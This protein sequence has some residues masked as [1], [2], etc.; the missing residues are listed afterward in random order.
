MHVTHLDG[1]SDPAGIEDLP[2]LLAEL[3]DANDEELEVAAG[4]PYGWSA[5]AYASGTVVLD[6]AAQPHEPQHVLYGVSRDEMLTILTEVMS[7][8]VETA[9]ARPWT[10]E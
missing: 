2:A 1:S 4:D 7:G 5:S 9:L 8:D 6:H 3:D 10:L